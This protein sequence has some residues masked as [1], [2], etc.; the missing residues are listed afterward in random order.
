MSTVNE[1]LGLRAEG[2]NGGGAAA[3][4]DGKRPDFL[5]V[6]ESALALA[7]RPSQYVGWEI[8]SAAKQLYQ[9]VNPSD[10]FTLGPQPSALSPRPKRVALVW[11]MPYSRAAGDARMLELYQALHGSGCAMPERFLRPQEDLS[12]ILESRG[13][14]NAWFSLETKSDLESFDA[15]LV[16]E[17]GL[18]ECPGLSQRLEKIRAAGGRVRVLPGGTPSAGGPEA[19]REALDAWGWKADGTPAE[20]LAPYSGGVPLP[21]PPRP[22]PQSPRFTGYRVCLWRKGWSS[23]LS[24]LEQIQVVK[25]AVRRSGLPFALS[26]GKRGMM[27]ISFGTA[28]SVGW[29]SQSEFFDL[30]LEDRLEPSEVAA[31]LGAALPLG[32]GARRAVRIPRHFPSLEESANWAEFAVEPR[33]SADCDWS[34]V[35][36]F[37]ERLARGEAPAVTVLKEKPG[38]KVDVIDVREVFGGARSDGPGGRVLRLALRFGPKKNL[39]PERILENL[40]G[41]PLERVRAEFRVSREALALESKTGKLRYL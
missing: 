29:T 6:L 19:A 5:R 17:E 36:S 27:K 33:Q 25:Q 14:P 38:L 2:L 32:F 37:G 13:F 23:F 39:K 31:R 35:L 3:Q 28:A 30:E 34:P 41:W 7:Q 40:L 1:G 20:A 15:W 4:P 18:S 8:G 26:V 12:K 16:L 21:E 10:F 22:R 11:P 24:H 9:G